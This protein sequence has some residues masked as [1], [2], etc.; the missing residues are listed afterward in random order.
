M[1]Y[2]T[3]LRNLVYL[4]RMYRMPVVASYWDSV[5]K[6]NDYQKRRF[7]NLVVREMFNTVGGKKLAVLRLAHPHPSP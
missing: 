3:H 5:I 7:A 1:C 6:M 2:E 4:A